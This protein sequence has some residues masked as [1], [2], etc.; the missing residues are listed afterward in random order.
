MAQHAHTRTHTHT[1]THTHTPKESI[2]G[3]LSVWSRVVRLFLC[4]SKE[5]RRA[6][7]FQNV[8][9]YKEKDLVLHTRTEIHSIQTNTQYAHERFPLWKWHSAVQWLWR[10]KGQIT[11]TQ[12][13]VELQTR[14]GTPLLSWT[15]EQCLITSSILYIYTHTHT[16]RLLATMSGCNWHNT[17]S[18]LHL[19]T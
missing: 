5:D 4:I 9:F 15:S 16:H 1:H 7:V 3:E 18:S 12:I 14:V 2:D 11:R 6:F 19:T 13:W 10:N 17:S 8:T